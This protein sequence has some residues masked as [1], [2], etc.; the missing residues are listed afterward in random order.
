MTD[1]LDRARENVVDVVP[2]LVTAVWLVA[3]LTGQEWWLPAMLVGY[4]VVVPTTAI[5]FGDEDEVDESV[6]GEASSPQASSEADDP[7]ETAKRRYA[8]GE[9]GEREFERIVEQLLDTE[10]DDGTNRVTPDID[11]ELDFERS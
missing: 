1:A 6:D 2:L 3:L 4:I 5:L 8:S 7:L 11:R 9:I 10:E